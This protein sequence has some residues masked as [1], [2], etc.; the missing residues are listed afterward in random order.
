MNG[1]LITHKNC[2]DGATAALVGAAVGL[3]PVF[4]EPDRVEEGLVSITDD[5]PVLLADVSLRLEAWNS[6]QHRIQQ[7][8]DHHQTAQV[9]AGFPNVL[10]DESRSGAHLMY[11]YAVWQC[12]MTPSLAFERLCQAVERYDL[13]KP[14]HDFGQDLN[15]L[16]HHLG[17]E[18]YQSRFGQGW[19]A[20]VSQEADCLAELI[21]REHAVVQTHLQ[22]A[23]RR[24]QRL[25]FPLYGVTLSEEGA[26]NNV[27][28]A[29]IEQRQAALVLV[30]KPD[31]RLS[32]RTDA[33]IDAARLM[34]ELFQGGGHPRAAGGRL[35]TDQPQDLEELLSQVEQYLLRS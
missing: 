26:M 14:R 12:G 5:G 15:R 35:A 2:L 11:D 6:W 17:Y 22:S 33:H 27:A 10:V 4:V 25:P 9:L 31:G 18:W 32:A 24:Q 8:L 21:Q 16:F 13:W 19:T 3:T 28:H 20:F 1:W 23:I 7:V 30:L 34:E 29:L